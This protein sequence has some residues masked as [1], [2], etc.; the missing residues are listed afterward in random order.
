MKEQK[1]TER[2]YSMDELTKA[3]G[4]NG[5]IR[6]VYFKL[7]PGTELPEESFG[8]DLIGIKILIVDKPKK[9][10]NHSLLDV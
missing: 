5:S 3:L 7:T 9:K 10:P 8:E 4:I 2:T 1:L 6:E